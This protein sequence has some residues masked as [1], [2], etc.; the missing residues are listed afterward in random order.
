MQS[1]PSLPMVMSGPGFKT[2]A[3]PPPPPPPTPPPPTF[4]Q[5]MQAPASNLL[6]TLMSRAGLPCNTL[7]DLNLSTKPNDKPDSVRES[8]PMKQINK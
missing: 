6:E 3:L 1:V 4:A 5:Q 7:S 2:N 8:S